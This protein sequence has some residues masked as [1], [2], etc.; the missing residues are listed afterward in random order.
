MK[1]TIAYVF[2]MV[3]F[4]WLAGYSGGVYAWFTDGEGKDNYLS[5]GKN[6]VEIVEEFPDPGIDPGKNIKKRVEFTNTGTVPCFI[7]A[8]Y[9]YSR[10][11]AQEQTALEFGSDKWKKGKDEFYYYCDSIVPGEKT[12]PFLMAVKVKAEGGKPDPFDLIIYTETVQS[13]GHE[14]AQEAF[15]YLKGQGGQ[16]ET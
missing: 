12:E 2:P 15:E 8:K 16:H 4:A 13:A 1:K 11:D 5:V 10:E 6:E 7:R 9:Y 3:M 14:N